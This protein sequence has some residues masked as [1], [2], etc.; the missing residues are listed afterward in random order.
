[1]HNF[2]YITGLHLIENG[3]TGHK[4]SS[5][6]NRTLPLPFTKTSCVLFGVDAFVATCFQVDDI[7]KKPFHEHAEEVITVVFTFCHYGSV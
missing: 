5:T 2:F 6:V 4:D 7:S 3:T 1:M